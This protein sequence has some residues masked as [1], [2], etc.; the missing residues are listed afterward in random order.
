MSQYLWTWLY[1]ANQMDPY[2]TPTEIVFCVFI[3][4]FPPKSCSP[5]WNTVRHIDRIT[6]LKIARWTDFPSEGSNARRYK[7]L[8][9]FPLLKI[10][11]LCKCLARAIPFFPR[12]HIFLQPPLI[13]ND[14]KKNLHLTICSLLFAEYGHLLEV[15]VPPWMI[16][17]QMVRT[18]KTTG[19]SGSMSGSWMSGFFFS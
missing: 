16:I 18:N 14:K 1:L 8:L 11:T 2:C 12:S 5:N 3:S 19:W 7:V 17:A 6:N 9:L 10:S 15:C 4:H 13:T